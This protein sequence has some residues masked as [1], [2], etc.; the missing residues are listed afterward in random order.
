MGLTQL[1]FHLTVT[2][3]RFVVW[4]SCVQLYTQSVGEDYCSR[5]SACITSFSNS[6]YIP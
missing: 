1:V 3:A 4:E 2:V 5:K 6:I